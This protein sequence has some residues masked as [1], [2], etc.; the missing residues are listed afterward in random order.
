MARKF[1]PACNKLNGGSATRCRCGHEFAASTIVQPRTTK[2]CPSCKREQ[3]LLLEVCG[4]G[5][6]FDDVRELREELEESVRMGWSYVVLGV[7][8]FAIGIGIMI[9]TSLIWLAAS[10][11]GVALAVKG[12]FA[13]A[14]ARAELRALRA[15]A[16]VLPSAKVV[17]QRD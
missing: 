17:G 4:C 3:P 14:D 2:H 15:A 6:S 8:L 9:A 7:L 16:G 12:F 11:G 1:C 5:H 10:F 13:R